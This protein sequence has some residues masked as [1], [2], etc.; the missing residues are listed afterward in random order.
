MKEEVKK[1]VKEEVMEVVVIKED[2]FKTGE[3]VVNS[4]YTEKLD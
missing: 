2:L 1:E 3:N 4:V